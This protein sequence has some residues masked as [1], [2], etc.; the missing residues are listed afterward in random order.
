MTTQ[1]AEFGFSRPLDGEHLSKMTRL[2]YGVGA[3][4]S[5]AVQV[6][7]TLCDHPDGR[8]ENDAEHA[9]MVSLLA[10]TL[11]DE[12]FPKLDSGLVA[13]YANIHD[14]VDVY[15]DDTPTHAISAEGLRA[16][17]EREAAGLRQL[18]KEYEATAPSLVRLVQAYEEQ[19]D[20]ESRFVRMLD[21]LVTVSV[22]F[23]NHGRTM[24]EYF[25]ERSGHES[26]VNTRIQ[27]FLEDYPDQEAILDIYAELATF[28]Q[29]MTWPETVGN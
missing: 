2:V 16:R 17:A 19:K 25:R 7:C 13:K 29:D 28:M 12:F 20:P 10:A 9:Y 5:R 3:L 15:V 27:R 11:A 6:K 1:G 14:L 18:V 26:M 24:R 23:P 8:A 22:Q 21:K 4:A